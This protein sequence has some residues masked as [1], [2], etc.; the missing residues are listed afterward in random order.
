V[1]GLLAAI[2][3][4]IHLAVNAITPYEFHRDELLYLAMGR[5]LRLW[6]MDFPPGIALL[7]RGAQAVV[8]D[9]L[10][11]LRLLPAVAG[12]ALV[13]LAALLA[14]ELGG[15]WRAQ[16]LA[17][18]SMVA[19]PL[20]MRSANLFQPVVLDQVTWT[21]ALLALT[22][23]LGRAGPGSWLLL[24]LALGL[25]LLVK[26]SI[27]VIGIAIAVAVLLSRLRHALRTPWPWAALLIALA[28]GS[29]SL[30]GQVRLGFPVFG[31]LSDLGATQLERVTPL[32]FLTGQLLW[33]PST[34]LALAGLAGLF[35]ARRLEEFRGLGIACAVAFLLLLALHGKAY[36]IGP[37]YPALFAAGAVEVE[38]MGETPVAE[39]V[40][41]GAVTVLVAYGFVISPLGLP[42]LGPLRMS[43]YVE[44]LGTTAALRTNTGELE[45]LPQDYADMLGWK[46]Q[47]AAVSRVYHGLPARARAE[48]VILAGNYGEAGALE[49]YGPRYRLPPP[50]S[51]AGS[52]WF[53]GPGTRPGKVMLTI[54]VDPARLTGRFQRVR[55]VGRVGH[56]WAVAEERSVPIV[57]AEG[58]ARTLQEVW[59]SLAG[60]H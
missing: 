18:L 14:R 30:L 13:V 29:P 2:K 56:G 50:V 44:A 5:H 10:F 57:I 7:A 3:L 23:L 41:W 36:Y 32:D 40:N 4:A 12:T 17:A 49:L 51:P 54:G 16:A 46:A 8:G 19:S 1:I 22:R 38:A 35:G 60:P 6:A 21:V 15:G 26:F 31:Q 42:F 27:G 24:G 59:P 20:F 28:I 11:G 53:F 39:L 48:V 34:A 25:G 45:R 33:G 58:P 43:E 52:F 9:S 55:L 47:V 37:V